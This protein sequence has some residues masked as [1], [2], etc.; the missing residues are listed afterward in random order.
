MGFKATCLLWDL[1]FFNPVRG[2]IKLDEI[3]WNWDIYWGFLTPM[4][5]NHHRFGINQRIKIAKIGVWCNLGLLVFLMLL[6]EIEGAIIKLRYLI[7]NM[8]I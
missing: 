8:N 3:I 6:C 1:R 4:G 7:S 5:W 2:L